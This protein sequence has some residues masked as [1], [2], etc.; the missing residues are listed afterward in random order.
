MRPT[1]D[2]F[3]HPVR[4]A[5]ILV[6]SDGY[7]LLRRIKWRYEDIGGK[8][9]AK[10]ACAMHTAIREAVEETDGKLFDPRDT[11]ADCANRLAAILPHCETH[12]NPRSKYLCYIVHVPVHIRHLPMHRFGLTE[13]TEWGTLPHYYK[14]KQRLPTNL[15]PRIRLLR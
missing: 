4:A 14:W 2:H 13:T 10:D 7:V 6:W 3:G 8:T 5:G 12:Y 1:F 9:D 15:H 11:H